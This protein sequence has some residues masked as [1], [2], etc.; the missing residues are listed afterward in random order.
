MN[1]NQKW[2]FDLEREENIA[3]KGKNA[4]YQHF[5]LSHN[6]F[7]TFLNPFPNRPLFLRVCSISL[8]KT[9]WEKEKLLVMSNFSISH[10]VLYPFVCKLSIWKSLKFVV[11]ERVKVV[12]R[13]DCVVKSYRTEKGN[14]LF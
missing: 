13:Q 3:G 11:W 14:F 6:V 1:I 12:K 10:C 7:K 2:K 4:G 5:L 9:L 8:L